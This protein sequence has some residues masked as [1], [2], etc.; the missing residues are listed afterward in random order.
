M[1]VVHHSGFAHKRQSDV[2]FLCHS[3]V[4]IV[5]RRRMWPSIRPRCVVVHT[6]PRTSIELQMG[7]SCHSNAPATKKA[8]LASSY[9]F[10]GYMMSIEAGY[11]GVG[12]MR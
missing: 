8:Q 6:Y 11:V 10:L 2:P 1:V 4:Y 7:S 5:H 9:V 3:G 12:S